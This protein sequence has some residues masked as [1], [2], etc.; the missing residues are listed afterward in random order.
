MKILGIDSAELTG[1]AVVSRAPDGTERLEQH[2]VLTIR[3]AADVEL[4]VAELAS[5]NP[6]LVTVEEPFIHPKYP[7]TGLVLAR[8]LG[9]WLQAFEARGFTTVTI[10]ASMWQPGVLPGITRQTRSAQRKAA[11]VAFARE[12][13]GVEVGEDAADAIALATFAARTASRR[14]A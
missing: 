12:R 14:A 11:A 2:G 6:D 9:R 5:A 8:L 10:P 4:A 13:F 3:A 1:F 7:M